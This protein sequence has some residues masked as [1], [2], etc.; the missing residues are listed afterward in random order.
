[1]YDD[2]PFDKDSH[3]LKLQDVGLT[4][5]YIADCEALA[6]IAETLGKVDDA[7]QVLKTAA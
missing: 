6:N 5:M 7:R 4:S 1:M 2:V 3:Q